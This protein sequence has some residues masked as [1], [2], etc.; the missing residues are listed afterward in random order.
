VVLFPTRKEEEVWHLAQPVIRKRLVAEA[1]VLIIL[2]AKEMRLAAKNRGT[3]YGSEEDSVEDEQCFSGR[4]VEASENHVR[5]HFDG[6][7]KTD[8]TWVEVDS[9]KLFLDGGRWKNE[10]AREMPKLHYWEEMDSKRRCTTK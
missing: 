5:I 3:G 7:T 10:M 4:V 8:D 1:R 2:P 9:P 6:L